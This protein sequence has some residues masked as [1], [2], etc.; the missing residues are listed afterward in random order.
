[1]SQSLLRIVLVSKHILQNL[2][3]FSTILL[4]IYISAQKTSSTQT[5][6]NKHFCYIFYNS[7]SVQKTLEI[8]HIL[9]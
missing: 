5:L 4:D 8:R 9:V 2:N 1:M 7:F 3:F 6:Y